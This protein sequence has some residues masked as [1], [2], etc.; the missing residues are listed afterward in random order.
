MFTSSNHTPSRMGASPHYEAR[1][2]DLFRYP[3]RL[4][5]AGPSNTGKTS[6]CIRLVKHYHEKFATILIC[7]ST[8]HP[9]QHEKDFSDKVIVSKDILNPIS[10]KTQADDHILLILDD[11]FT[12]A[13][14]SPEI[15]DTF[16]KGRHENISI[17]LIT[18]NLFS[19]GKYARNISLN[20]SAF[21]LFKQRDISQIETL[22]RQIFGKCDAKKFLAA[23]KDTV[24][25]S[26]YSYL[27]LDLIVDTPDELQLRSNLFNENGPYQVVHKW[28]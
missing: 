4:I 1:Y 20:A 10:Y 8:Q 13:L 23:Y 3:C 2:L 24:L 28:R 11:C 15:A 16:T 9:L 19:F 12:E 25:S 5:L 7:G 26:P 14:N 22:G 18:Q 6:V 17:V 21:I 27:L